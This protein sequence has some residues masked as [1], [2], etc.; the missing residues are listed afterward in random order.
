[1][2]QTFKVITNENLEIQLIIKFKFHRKQF[3][4]CEELSVI[5]SVNIQCDTIL[6]HYDFILN[7]KPNKVTPIVKEYFL[8]N[9]K[10]PC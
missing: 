7:K 4:K 5:A 2:C 8:K 1:M 3:W 10:N 9:F 6:M